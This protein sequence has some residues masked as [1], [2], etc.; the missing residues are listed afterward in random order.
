MDKFINKFWANVRVTDGCWFWTGR[1]SETGYGIHYA[2]HRGQKYYRAHRFS[3][4]LA[5]F[6]HPRKGLVIAHTCHNR[7]CVNP[8]HLEEVTQGKNMADAV[9]RGSF[10][11]ENHGRAKLTEQD[12]LAIRR[13]PF[14]N[15]ILAKRY[16]VHEST[17]Y[18]AR[19][20]E[21]WQHLPMPDDQKQCS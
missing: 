9:V 10:Q 13:S 7:A 18:A 11:G 3:W 20:G 21:R 17:I 6:R 14:S 16:G 19:R 1:K 2:N 15:R 5:N 12:V 8:T 4:A